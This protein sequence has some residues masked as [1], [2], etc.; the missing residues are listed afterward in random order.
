LQKIEWGKMAR[1]ISFAFCL[2]R[3]PDFL[4]PFGEFFFA[5]EVRRA[6]KK[7]GLMNVPLCLSFPKNKNV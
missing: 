4:V 7:E 2:R 3:F 5:S 1:E 6:K